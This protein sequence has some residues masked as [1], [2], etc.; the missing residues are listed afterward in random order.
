MAD[1]VRQLQD[2]AHPRRD[3]LRDEQPDRLVGAPERGPVVDVAA[4]HAAQCIEREVE[5]VVALMRHGR[6]GIEQQRVLI[7]QR[8]V[9]DDDA[10]VLAGAG[11]R[12]ADGQRREA[13]AGQ[14]IREAGALRGVGDAQIDGRRFVFAAVRLG[15]Q[16]IGGRGI[17]G[18][19]RL[20]EHGIGGGRIGDRG[21]RGRDRGFR[22]VAGAIGFAVARREQE[23]RA[24]GQTDQRDARATQRAPPVCSASARMVP[25]EGACIERRSRRAG[26]ATWRLPDPA[27]RGSDAPEAGRIMAGRWRRERADDR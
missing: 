17:D 10:G 2:A 22:V 24:E 23:P 1:V 9:A 7:G 15:E 26:A 6:P 12:R 14:G 21:R 5:H 25:T 3:L 13:R 4:E 11:R 8:R 20:G 16:R 19:R 27:G 18:G